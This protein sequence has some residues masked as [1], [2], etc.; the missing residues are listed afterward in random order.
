MR[1]VVS[2][3]VLMLPALAKEFRDLEFARP[4]GV[5]LTLDASLVDS[6]VPQPAVI[7]IHGG[8]WEAGDKRTYIRPWFST[9]S[10]AGI[11]WFSVDYRLGP[12]FKHPAAVE[13]IEAA[14]TFIRNNAR[15]FNIDPSRV[16]LMGE[17]AGGHLA[18]LVALRGKVALTG[19]VS[20]YGIHDLSLWATQ[21]GGAL[22][23]NIAGYLPDLSDSTLRNAS[24]DTYIR[25]SNPPALFVHGTADRGVPWQQSTTMCDRMKQAGARCEVFLIEGA[26]HGVENWEK[27][28]A[29]QSWKP[30][31][32]EWLR[33]VL[34]SR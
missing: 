28:E 7:L 21:R 25:R 24:P 23:K 11:S 32:V 20:F 4:G 16:A 29:F 10:R 15:L 33:A 18:M 26:P 6:S 30:K 2:L 22:P 19:V 34:E 27:D 5:P 31:T 9:L 17:S 14:V 1:L 12:R 3:V 8:G 13:D